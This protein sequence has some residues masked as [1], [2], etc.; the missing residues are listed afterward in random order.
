[1][2]RL[3]LVTALDHAT[4]A[5]ATKGS[6]PVFECAFFDGKRV[7]AYD[8]ELAI[9]AA[10][11]LDLKGGVQAAPLRT[12]VAGCGSED[13]TATV[14]GSAVLFRAGRS[15]LTLPLFDAEQAASVMPA[16]LASPPEDVHTLR[17][18]DPKPLMDALARCSAFAGDD[19]AHPQRAG[20]TVVSGKRCRL[21]ASDNLTL[22]RQLVGGVRGELAVVL[23]PRWLTAVTAVGSVSR[24]VAGPG[25]VRATCTS[26]EGPVVVFTRTC[27]D[28]AVDEFQKTF[29][30]VV[31]KREG[32]PLPPK[33][34]E[35]CRHVARTTKAVGGEWCELFVKADVLTV[36]SVGT[37]GTVRHSVK[38][39][40]PDARAVVVA[41]ELLRV[42][43]STDRWLIE[44]TAV[45]AWGDR[46]V[47][48]VAASDE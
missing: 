1:M 2:Q 46:V 14:E 29:D 38:V 11:P 7:S 10:C 39:S 8:G 35:A 45:V 41:S 42:L 32:H 27:D 13:V 6:A 12:W 31:G 23:P 26:P 40:H 20:V 15:R 34:L 24:L 17:I 28:V 18:D 5:A 4:K 21:W 19:P 3:A 25:W 16:E 36:K 33:V 43:D 9:R 48:L 22:T 37:R 47:N 30:E 44:P